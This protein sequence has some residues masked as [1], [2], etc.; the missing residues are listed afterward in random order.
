MVTR[1]GTHWHPQVH[2]VPVTCSHDMLKVVSFL[3]CCGLASA[4]LA[5]PAAPVNLRVNRIVS[6][7]V[8]DSTPT[9]SWEAPLSAIPRGTRAVQHEVQVS[10]TS[11]FTDL[12]YGSG[13]QASGA[14]SAMTLPANC[15]WEPDTLYYW[16]VRWTSSSAPAPSPWA[17]STFTFGLPNP[18]DW[19]NATWIACGP[20]ANVGAAAAGHARI[21]FAVESAQIRRATLYLACVGWCEARFNGKKLGGDNALE[22][23]WTQWNRRIEYVAYD[24]DAG[25]VAAGGAGSNALG[26]WLGSGWPGHL[27]LEPA[28]KVLL[29][30]ESD[31]GKKQFVTSSSSAWLSAAGPVV[32]NDIY[33]GESYDARL[34]HPGWDEAGF[35][36]SGWVPAAPTRSAE[37]CGLYSL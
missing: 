21:E 16:R 4:A 29:S 23:G 9:L 18:S 34:E 20:G 3:L 8:D 31:D 30:L 25:A 24:I 13:P 26:V 19:H 32:S 6:P 33:L 15:S 7:T 11:A 28:A 12:V 37:L 14:A 27:G 35:D 36:A 17:S 1:V 10:L 5:Q 2:R 22:P